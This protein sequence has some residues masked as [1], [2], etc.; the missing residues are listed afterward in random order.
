MPTLKLVEIR[1]CGAGQF[2]EQKSNQ[3]KGFPQNFS[4]LKTSESSLIY[5]RTLYRS[6]DGFILWVET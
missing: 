6:I 5:L 3:S 1:Q 2:S 4:Y